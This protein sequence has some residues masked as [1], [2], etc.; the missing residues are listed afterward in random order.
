MN[1]PGYAVGDTAAPTELPIAL[2][3]MRGA[4]KSA[5]GA[6]L[7]TRLG[8]ALFDL[9]R[10]TAP[11][12]PAGALLARVGEREFRERELAALR[13]VLAGGGPAGR[14]VLATGGGAV[15]T[16]AGRALVRERT[17]AVWLEAPA[18]VLA[19]RIARDPTP[20]PPLDGP[21]AAAEV[22][23]ILARREALYADAARVRIDASRGDPDAVARAV[24]AALDELSGRSA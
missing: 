14:F 10:E 24:L 23:R 2:I 20:R 3:G 15:E 13:R 8:L 12:E 19:A 18:D 1:N 16:D 6:A 7:A 22:A 9:D 17:C 21:D 11:D 5:V 4:G